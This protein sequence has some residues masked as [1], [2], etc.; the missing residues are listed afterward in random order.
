M[1]TLFSITIVTILFLSGCATPYELHSA[2]VLGYEN[3]AESL[4]AKGANVN[5]W[6]RGGNTPLMHAVSQGKAK[7]AKLL[8]DNGANMNVRYSDGNTL[9]CTAIILGYTE[10]TNMLISKGAD[11][12]ARTTNGIHTPLSWAIHKENIKVAKLLI[13]KG[14]DVNDRK[15]IGGNTHLMSAAYLSNIKVAKLL[16]DNGA[17]VNA[18]NR[19]WTPLMFAK[20]KE[21]ANFLISNGADMNARLS[22][23]R[24]AEEICLNNIRSHELAQ[25]QEAEQKQQQDAARQRQQEEAAQQQQQQASS[26]QG[27]SGGGSGFV[28]SLFN[29]FGAGA[30]NN[31]ASKIRAEN[32]IGSRIM[33]DTMSSMA[34]K[35]ANNDTSSTVG[36]G[37]GDTVFKGTMNS[38]LDKQD[39]VMQ[40]IPGSSGLKMASQAYTNTIRDEVDRKVQQRQQTETYAE[41]NSSGESNTQ[42]DCLNR[43]SG[44]WEHPVGGRWEFQD[45]KARMV[46]NAR[47]YGS[48]AKQITEMAI[49]ACEGSTMKYKLVRAALINTVDP[50]MAYDK[51][52]ANTPNLPKWSKTHTQAYSIS[53]NALKFGNYTYMKQ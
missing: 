35:V 50:S 21:M 48:A 36:G 18:E 20:T 52:P 38:L 7:I 10:I 53:G 27:S 6:D 4:I 3:R 32:T 2:A 40:S 49:F 28:G 44:A 1:K 45:N 11:V 33:G 22:D 46:L 26:N 47:N 5:E 39:S 13:E 34:N 51:T 14:A 31:V 17:D 9:L 8:I 29:A 25:Q 43:L 15:S 16:I 23:G 24:T 37:V 12:N 41:N 30:M 42:S 19:G